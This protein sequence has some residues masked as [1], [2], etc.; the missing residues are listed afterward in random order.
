MKVHIFE[1]QDFQEQPGH[2]SPKATRNQAQ[3][4]GATLTPFGLQ[5]GMEGAERVHNQWINCS[6]QS[7]KFHEK[8]DEEQN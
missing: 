6:K 3:V 1:G 7:R 2:I 8:M 5:G 4:Q